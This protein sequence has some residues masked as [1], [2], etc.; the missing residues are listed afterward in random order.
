MTPPRPKTPR[1]RLP[2]AVRDSIFARGAHHQVALWFKPGEREWFSDTFWEILRLAARTLPWDLISEQPK[3]WVLMHVGTVMDFD[4]AA[5]AF[6]PGDV[7][8]AI[9]TLPTACIDAAEDLRETLR[10]AKLPGSV[11]ATCPAP[12]PERVSFLPWA[13]LGS[14]PVVVKIGADQ[15]PKWAERLGLP[16]ILPDEIEEMQIDRYLDDAD[17]TIDDKVAG[18]LR[19]LFDHE[20]VQ[21]PSVPV[22]QNLSLFG[23][24]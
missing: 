14:G 10:K 9:L 12:S 8:G 20:P 15:S 18:L 21:P 3:P 23:G 4:A 17:S 13:V 5:S 22:G 7:E 11:A 24:R 16:V 6:G 19:Q 2:A 1:A